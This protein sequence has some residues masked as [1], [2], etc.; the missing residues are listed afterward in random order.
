MMIARCS[1]LVIL[2]WMFVMPV[3]AAENMNAWNYFAPIYCEGN[4]QYKTFFVTEDIYEHASPGL[5]DLRIVDE[6]GEYIP[7]YIQ[8]GFS[9]VRENKIIYKSEVVERF[10]KNNDSYIDVQI[11]PL[12]NNTD[13]S[14]NS[15]IF[16]LPK[17]NFLK[18]IEIYGSNDGDKWSYIGRDYVFKTEEREKKEVAVGHKSKYTY[19]RI[20]VLDN[21]EDITLTNVNLSDQY[22]DSQWSS[23]FKMAQVNFD[24]KTDKTD[25]VIT[26]FND[27][28]LKIKQIVIEAEG[29]FQRNYKLYGDNPNG[30]PLKSGELYNLQLENV[31]ISGTNIDLSKTPTSASP[32][33][34]KI[35]NRDDRPLDI[36]F[37][38]IEYYIDKIVFPGS[39]NASYRLHF[40][41]DKA[42]KPKY[43]IE[44]QKTYIEKERQ[45]SS[46]LGI[47]EEEHRTLPPA[48]SLNIKYV[49]NGIIVIISIFLIALLVSRMNVK[50]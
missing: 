10:K 27:K 15:L 49:F 9:I 32:I 45:D 31:K 47:I 43:E 35:D 46:K 34:I 14:G 19:Y 42:T 2:T 25:S 16:E 29:N 20:V 48:S 50:K 4:N 41:N 37:I 7:F 8:H 11:I 1:L 3:F 18:Y 40:G 13:V 39:G 12:K 44:L 6:Q 22:T 36:K 28:K 30:A 21:P 17:E 23:Y 33:T 38:K 24:I 26:F 5:A